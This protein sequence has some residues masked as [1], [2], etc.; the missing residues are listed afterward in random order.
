MDILIGLAVAALK[1]GVS[2]L[3]EN[4][5]GQVLVNQGIDMG[6]KKLGQY[7]ERYK[8]ELSRILTDKSLREMNVPE[9]YIVYVQEEIKELLRSVSLDEDLFRNCRYDANSL[10]EALYQ[11]YKEQKKILLN[12]KV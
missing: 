12:M 4:E 8:Q 6:S 3:G 9:D 7:L 10:A 5:F 2:G 11:K 1:A